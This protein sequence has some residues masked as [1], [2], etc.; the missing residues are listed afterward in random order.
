MV[1]DH[2]GEGPRH[3]AAQSVEFGAGEQAFFAMRD[4]TAE[5]CELVS[6]APLAEFRSSTSGLP[7]GQGILF[8]HRTSHVSYLRSML[9]VARSSLDHYL[10]T[11]Y[12]AGRS[13]IEVGS[14]IVSI[15]AGDVV[16][17][18]MS[19][20]SRTFVEG[21]PGADESHGVTFMLPRGLLAPL[22]ATPDSAPAVVIPGDEAYGRVV[23]DHILSVRRH[24]AG[25]APNDAAAVLQTLAQLV[26]GG[27]RA[28]PGREPEITRAE[29]IARYAAIKRHI[30]STLDS[31]TVDIDRVCHT[32]G[33]SRAAL[34]R[35]FEAD[36]GVVR[37]VR[38]IQLR[39][40]F[41]AL[42]S[43]AHRHLRVSDIALEHGFANES[44]FIR[45]FRREFDTT[46][47]EVR[48]ARTTVPFRGD[49]MAIIRTLDVPRPSPAG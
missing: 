3:F 10:A 39:R 14:E 44:A 32:F 27:L 9:H 33:V 40:A 41:A 35:L 34:Y 46:P 6:C 38:R 48:R 26:A 31:P 42:M 2:P 13:R 43:P 4:Q 18:D 45:A 16:V 17:A 23:R 25:L 30:Q 19:V 21:A 47:G 15:R 22:L 36:G 29:T 1:D 37:F 5:M 28:A 12:L 49:W 7:L 11:M 8:E 20:P 24:G